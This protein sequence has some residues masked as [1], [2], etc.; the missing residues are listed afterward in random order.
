MSE[1]QLPGDPARGQ[2][3]VGVQAAYDAI[4]RTY[5]AELSNEL[6]GKPMDKAMLNGFVE[7]VGT[8]T[9]ADVGCGPGH[10]TRLLAER[11]AD[12]VGVDLS[13]GMIDI[14]REQAPELAFEVGSM[15]KLP[16]A[17]EAW[18]GAVALYSIIHLTAD[19]RAVAFGEFARTIRAGG[20]LLVS[21]HIDSPDFAAGEV[22]HLTDWFGERVELDGFFFEPS[23]VARD[24]EAAGFTIMSTTIRRPLPGAEYPSRRCYLLARRN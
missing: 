22:N 5:Q 11:H 1:T 4:A 7:L 10:V 3:A 23:D 24:A 18:A 6:D 12:V 9:I 14:A 16:V 19:E 17:D 13:P 20:W 2:V 8:G 15:L 21:F